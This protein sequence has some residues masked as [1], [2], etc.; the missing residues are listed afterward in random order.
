MLLWS[1]TREDAFQIMRFGGWLGRRVWR[2]GGQDRFNAL[3]KEDPMLR[4]SLNRRI[5]L[6][7]ESKERQSFYSRDRREGRTSNVREAVLISFE[8][9]SPSHTKIPCWTSEKQSRSGR[10]RRYLGGLDPWSSKVA[11]GPWAGAIAQCPSLHRARTWEFSG[12]RTST[13]CTCCLFGDFRNGVRV[14]H[15]TRTRIGDV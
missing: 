11:K 13:P 8:I 10:G 15:R 12:V 14:T 6:N 7:G 3:R 4:F 9:K 1:D 5:P 2:V